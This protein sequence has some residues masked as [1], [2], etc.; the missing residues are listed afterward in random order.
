[1]TA[2][3]VVTESGLRVHRFRR[4]EL[5]LA[6]QAPIES[7]GLPAV[8]IKRV[9]AWCQKDLGVVVGS[10]GQDGLVSHGICPACSARALAELPGVP[11]SLVH[12]GRLECGGPVIGCELASADAG[13][14]APHNSRETGAN[15]AAA[16]PVNG[17][18]PGRVTGTAT[19]TGQP[20]AVLEHPSGGPAASSTLKRP[21][22]WMLSGEDFG[23]S[24]RWARQQPRAIA[25]AIRSMVGRPSS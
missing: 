2:A 10:P 22:F 12:G 7:D 3:L 16:G 8:F 5:A 15:E 20:V 13:L 23:R 14:P 19:P 21:L 18:S 24:I 25:E 9:C 4:P 17:T 11:K 6:A 1:M